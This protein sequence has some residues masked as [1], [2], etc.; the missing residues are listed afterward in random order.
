MNYYTYILICADQTLYTGWTNDLEARLQAHND[1]KGSKY[2]RA[3]LPVSLVCSWAFETRSEAM[4][5][6]VSVKKLSRADK[7]K[8]VQG[9]YP[10]QVAAKLNSRPRCVF[11]S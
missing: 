10:D 11:S 7:F 1:A 3:R 8:L 2:T 6:E 9:E 4:S 5:F